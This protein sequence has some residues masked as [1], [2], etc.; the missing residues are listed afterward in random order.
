MCRLQSGLIPLPRPLKSRFCENVADQTTIHPARTHWRERRQP[1]PAHARQPRDTRGSCHP[2]GKS[3]GEPA[4]NSAGV[5]TR[6]NPGN[7][8]MKSPTLVLHSL[9]RLHSSRYT[10]TRSLFL[11]CDGFSSAPTCA[12]RV[13]ASRF[14]YSRPSFSKSF[15][16]ALTIPLSRTN[17]ISVSQWLWTGKVGP[18]ITS[19]TP[20]LL[21]DRSRSSYPT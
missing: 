21:C 16:V 10:R 5:M 6:I 3:S 19:T 2:W 14:A 12:S 11:R 13:S 9:K 20:H 7:P 18:T 15:A 1:S 17:G 8:S 4:D